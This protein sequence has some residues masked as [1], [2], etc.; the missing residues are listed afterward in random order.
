MLNKIAFLGLCIFLLIIPVSFAVSTSYETSSVSRLVGNA[1]ED[2]INQL[3]TEELNLNHASYY[4]Q[5]PFWSA[6]SF[7]ENKNVIK[8][9]FD[10][11]NIENNW[12]YESIATEDFRS[13]ELM[14]IEGQEGYIKNNK[15]TAKQGSTEISPSDT[16]AWRDDFA[17]HYPL[18][19]FDSDYAGLAIPNKPSFVNELTRY[20]QI[21]APNFLHSREFT[22]A[23]I[24]NIG[25]KK[26]LGH[27]FREARNRYYSNVDPDSDEMIGI[28]LMSYHL[29]GNPLAITT[30]PNHDRWDLGDYCGY[31]LGEKEDNPFNTQGYGIQ[32]V[33]DNIHENLDIHY[34]L[35]SEEGYDIININSA[36]NNLADYELVHPVIVKHHDLP[37]DAIITNIS[38]SFSNPD[39][40]DLNIPEYEDGLVNRSCYSNSFEDYLKNTVSYKEDKQTIN[41][42]INPLEM[43]NCQD[44]EFKLYKDVQYTIDY[45]SPSPIYF[46]NLD[47]PRKILPGNDFN[48]SFALKYVKNENLAGEIELFADKELIYQK[49]I[50]SNVPFMNILLSSSEKEKF[51]KY[52]LR[53]VESGET[54]TETEF[55]IET[56]ILDFSLDI[57]ETV[58]ESAEV[59]LKIRNNKDKKVNITVE[60]NLLSTEKIQGE[61][62]KHTLEPGLNSV[63]YF[64]DG[65]LQSEK[66]YKLRFDLV[67]ENEQEVLNDLIVTNHKPMLDAISDITVEEGEIVFI[68]VSAY[69]LE[70]DE[71]EYSIG[72]Q[73]FDQE[74]NIFTWQ[75]QAGDT[76]EYEFEITV[77]DGYESASQKFNVL[78]NDVKEDEEED[79][80]KSICSKNS[81]CG[82]DE[83]TGDPLCS[84]GNVY[85]G[86]ITYECV[87]PGESS[88]ECMNNTEKKIKYICEDSCS[89]GECVSI[90]CS[91]DS[92][93]GTDNYHSSSFCKEDD[94][95]R[96]YREYSCSSPG[97]SDSRC[98]YEDK[99]KLITGCS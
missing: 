78:V 3:D 68:E 9:M 34:S 25:D 92:D 49:E 38:Y 83:F 86:Y 95:Y 30:T 71:I 74:D 31:L 8:L 46:D 93:C 88:A 56:R 37:L 91:S 53:Y 41:I 39:I 20:S 15:P 96:E 66:A 84:S 50:D 60:D 33:K 48:L 87:N 27:S 59:E 26:T 61:V 22:R 75:T 32:E 23:V 51:T 52:K 90:A 72:D 54:L 42:F 7:D 82:S 13:N 40:L 55:D 29:Y 6:D 43:S 81:D 69:D 85:Q 19:I 35:E 28:T 99:D 63:S 21:I 12:D 97:T 10:Q 45:I 98:S 79:E 62:K 5:E 65:L 11:Y 1:P 18:F 77:S 80:E 89:E 76:G 70:D 64:Y 67:Y 58:K 14:I 44:N 36:K 57:P 17:E 73:R 4:G 16:R 2:L 94:V 47:Y 24:C